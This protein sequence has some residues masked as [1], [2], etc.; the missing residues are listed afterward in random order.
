MAVLI[1]EMVANDESY[2]ESIVAIHQHRMIE[3]IQIE[4]L[5]LPRHRPA[6]W[7]LVLPCY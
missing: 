2:D 6:V 5:I 4:I 7:Y 1:L 3:P